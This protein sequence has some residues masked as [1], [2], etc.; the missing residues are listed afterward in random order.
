[1][2]R[3]AFLIIIISFLLL[4]VYLF[5][6]EKETTFYIGISN[7]A[8][9]IDLNVVVDDTIILNDS[10]EYNPYKFTIVKK[11]FRGFMQKISISSNLANKTL[12]K[13]MLLVFNQHIIIEYFPDEKGEG[14]FDIR[15]Q[16]K[17]FYLE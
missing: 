16:I 14:F 15:N 7:P 8:N 17:P 12:E 10:I 3:K 6:R 9:P 1:M 2:K 5:L 4:L 11:N 13:N